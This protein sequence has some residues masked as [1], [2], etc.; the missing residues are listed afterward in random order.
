MRK[1]RRGWR[2]KSK[3]WNTHKKQRGGGGGLRERERK[4]E[5]RVLLKTEDAFT[6]L[7]LNGCK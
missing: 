1:E 3:K 5:C 4:D 2:G 7:G 6:S